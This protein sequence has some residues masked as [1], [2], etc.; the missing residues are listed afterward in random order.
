MISVPVTDLPLRADGRLLA[1]P[2]QVGITSGRVT[3]RRVMISFGL[4]PGPRGVI[5]RHPA[6]V[7]GQRRAPNLSL[8][9]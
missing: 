6:W 4:A 3:D 8:G 5:D 2:G 1:I 7:L 9:R